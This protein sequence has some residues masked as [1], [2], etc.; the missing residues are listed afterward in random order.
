MRRALLLTVSLALALPAAALASDVTAGCEGASCGC[1]T[2]EGA[3]CPLHRRGKRAKAKTPAFDANTIVA[4]YGTVTQVERQPTGVQL[5]VQVGARTLV[6]QLGP[7]DYVDGRMAFA[8]ADVVQFTG[9][10]VDIGGQPGVIATEIERQGQR[11]RLRD[12]DGTPRFG[13]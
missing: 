13:R 3:S 1:G 12:D 11:L 9:S 5:K 6:V 4:M 10:S 8:T 7:A 2:G